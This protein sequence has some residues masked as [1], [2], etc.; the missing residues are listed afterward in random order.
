M[1]KFG[2]AIVAAIALAA[3]PSAEAQPVRSTPLRRC[4]S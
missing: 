3:P 1:F 2:P 4:C